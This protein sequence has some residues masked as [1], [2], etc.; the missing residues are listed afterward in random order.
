[1]ANLMGSYYMIQAN[2]VSFSNQVTMTIGT[3]KKPTPTKPKYFL[4]LKLP[5]GKAVYLSSLY[6]IGQKGLENGFEGYSFEVDDIWYIL[7]I[8]KGSGQAEVTLFNST[9]SIN[10]VELGAKF[11][12]ISGKS[13][14]SNPS[15]S[16][17]K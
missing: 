17:R 15:E 13:D 4:L 10:N 6:P 9:F 12:P 5:N 8:D 16:G 7:T 11:T 3:R 1:M 2:L 14:F